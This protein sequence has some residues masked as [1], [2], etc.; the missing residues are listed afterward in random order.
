MSTQKNGN[1]FH[2]NLTASDY[3]K[4]ANSSQ[5]ENIIQI[6]NWL[7]RRIA[8]IN[9]LYA[10]EKSSG[11]PLVNISENVWKDL[12][13]AH[14]HPTPSHS[15]LTQSSGVDEH[16]RA[17][18]NQVAKTVNHLEKILADAIDSWDKPEKFLCRRK[19]KECLI[20]KIN[21]QADYLQL[22]A[23]T[24]KEIYEQYPDQ[25]ELLFPHKKDLSSFI[26]NIK[27]E[28]ETAPRY[29]RGQ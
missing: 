9:E 29:I 16:Y 1:E 23:L 24:L 6:S 26:D 13:K 4:I 8:E 2:K 25:D 22:I 18:C 5:S 3:R 14:E 11:L 17:C 27:P 15:F 20:K 7:P 28:K 21:Y 12:A 19:P 10:K